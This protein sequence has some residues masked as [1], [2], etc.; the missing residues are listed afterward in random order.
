MIQ[1]TGILQQKQVAAAFLSVLP[2]G[3]DFPFLTGTQSFNVTASGSWTLAES[4]AATWLTTQVT[5]GT[6]SRNVTTTVLKNLTGLD[7]YTTLILT[8]GSLEATVTIVQRKA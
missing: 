1:T 2:E 7:R 5:A 3:L 6:G 8:Q 4:P